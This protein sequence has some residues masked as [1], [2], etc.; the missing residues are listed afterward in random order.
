MYLWFFKNWRI[1]VC[2]NY[3]TDPWIPWFSDKESTD[4]WVPG[5]VS[6]QR[7]CETRADK[8]RDGKTRAREEQEL[9]KQEL[10]K[11]ILEETG[12]S[13]TRA[14]KT[15]TGKRPNLCDPETYEVRYKDQM[16]LREHIQMYQRDRVLC[17][18]N[19]ERYGIHYQI[20]LTQ[21]QFNV[22]VKAYTATT[23]CDL[24]KFGLLVEEI[25]GTNP[26][27]KFLDPDHSLYLTR[28]LDLED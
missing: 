3:W 10:E 28:P 21:D 14:A 6:K 18:Q 27:I 2:D 11:T 23:H 5:H 16:S 9:K 8:T 20:S 13:E 12:A 1:W 24:P 26:L 22:L 7:I 4:S 19:T 15:K 25:S 17:D